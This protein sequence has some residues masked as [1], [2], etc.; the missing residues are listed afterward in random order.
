MTRRRTRRRA[1]EAEQAQAAHALLSAI[2]DQSE[3]GTDAAHLRYELPQS[4]DQRMWGGVTMRLIA[5][6]I[7]IRVGDTH[8]RRA[9]AHGRRIGQY[10]AADISRARQYRDR[11]ADQA[12]RQRPTQM[13][14]PGME[15][16]DD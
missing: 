10:V 2:I 7:I 11:L 13:R 9:V 8:T 15:V 1:S 16:A 14:L 5:E 6:G 3:A 4:C 12:A